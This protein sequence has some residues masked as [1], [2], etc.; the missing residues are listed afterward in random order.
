MSS[1]RAQQQIW[2]AMGVV[3]VVV[4]AWI[5]WLARGTEGTALAKDAEENIR[6]AFQQAGL[7]QPI[8]RPV[9]AGEVVLIPPAGLKHQVKRLAGI[10]GLAV[11]VNDYAEDFYSQ[12][13]DGRKKIHCLIRCCGDHVIA[14]VVRGGKTDTAEAERLRSILTNVFPAN[15]VAMEFI[16]RNS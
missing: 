14:I 13:E 1:S 2:V 5:G 7:A 9:S 12:S 16:F 10:L 4:L 11:K 3:T 8:V 6:S 15:P